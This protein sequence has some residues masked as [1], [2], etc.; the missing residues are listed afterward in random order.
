MM[1]EACDE[2]VP[3]KG[4]ILDVSCGE[5]YLMNYLNQPGR[6]LTGLEPSKFS[7][8]RARALGFSVHEVPIESFNSKGGIYSSQPLR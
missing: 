3:A 8:E 5:G 6:E 4:K 7:A 1:N 2:L